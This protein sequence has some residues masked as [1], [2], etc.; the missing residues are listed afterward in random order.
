MRFLLCYRLAFQWLKLSN[1]MIAIIGILMTILSCILMGDWQSISNDPCTELSPFHNPNIL[2]KYEAAQVQKSESKNK[3]IV[4]DCVNPPHVWIHPRIYLNVNVRLSYV[5]RNMRTH[6]REIETCS[7]HCNGSFDQCLHY[8][9]DSNLCL[10]EGRTDTTQHPQDFLFDKTVH[11]YLCKKSNSICITIYQE[12]NSTTTNVFSK[13]N[14][15]IVQSQVLYL[16]Q[17]DLYT[18]AMNKINVKMPNL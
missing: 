12:S 4:A 5:Q 18:M 10:Q 8:N 7:K 14:L 15:H 16:L 3:E 9:F 1:S 6:C 2:K 11:H 17:V 13:D